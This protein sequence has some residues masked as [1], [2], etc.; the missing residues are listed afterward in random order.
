MTPCLFQHHAGWGWTSIPPGVIFSNR[1]KKMRH[2]SPSFGGSDGP[3]ASHSI[4]FQDMSQPHEIVAVIPIL[5]LRPL[6]PTTG[7]L[8]DSWLTTLPVSASVK[9]E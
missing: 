7:N 4:P 3:F 5:F 9:Q 2:T 6:T 8:P 1:P